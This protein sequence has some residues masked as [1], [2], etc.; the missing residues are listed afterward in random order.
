[1]I[2]EPASTE[3]WTAWD[4]FVEKTPETGFMQSSWWVEFRNYCGFENFGITLTDGND[5]VGG[6]VVLK[7]LCSEDRCFYY[8]QDGPVLPGDPLAAEAVFRAVLEDLEDRRR[9]EPHVVSHLRIEPRW[10]SLPGFVSGFR[11]I[12]PLADIYLEAR[13]TRCIDLRPSEAAIL[14]QMK[15]KGRYN[16]GLARRHGVSI[17]ED[18]SEQGL[19]DFQNI[20]EE[21][22]TRKGRKAKPPDYFEELMSLLS[23]ARRG[24]L[25]FAEYQGMRIATA[26]VVYF[27]PRATY[28]FGGSRDIHRQVMA[29]YLLHFEIMR[30]ARAL[31][32]E[33]YD[34]WGIAPANEPDHPWQC[35]SVFKAKF[36]GVE[37]RLVPTLDYVYDAAA[38]DCY[39]AEQRDSGDTGFRD[40]LPPERTLSPVGGE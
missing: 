33:W 37:V 5:I 31:G 4:S 1:M 12:P 11:A 24:S 40:P 28:F 8:I 21:T 10:L 14:A 6:A 25:F 22:A 27:G 3:R 30:K 32:H 36:G 2:S 16:I 23:P 9:A 7:Y 34:L 17:V 19:A 38:Y 39:V 15:P 18:N 20:Y 35:I 29:P 13:D 26:L